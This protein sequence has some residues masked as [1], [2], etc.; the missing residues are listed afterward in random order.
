MSGWRSPSPAESPLANVPVLPALRRAT[1]ALPLDGPIT[2]LAY[3]EA[4]DRFLVTTE[5][6]IYITDGAFSRVLRHTVV[7]TMFSVDLA[8]LA[9]G[10]FLAPDTVLAV[11]ENKSYVVLRESD[12]ADAAANYR[13]FLASFDKFDEAEP[14]AVHDR[15]GE[16]DVRDGGRLRPGDRVGLHDDG[17]EREGEAAGRVAIRPARHDA[18]GGVHAGAGSRVR[19]RLQ[20]EGR[21]ARRV[22]R[23]GC[24]VPRGQALRHQRRV[25]HAADD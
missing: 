16:D 22:L 12:R 13:Y 19:S 17:P 15:A 6:G 14:L 7:D 3:N 4:T 10:T 23:V 9:A 24:G 25:R 8:R 20:G 1:I 11:S 21:F 2:D 5:K 18:L